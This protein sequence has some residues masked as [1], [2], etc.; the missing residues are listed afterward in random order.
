MCHVADARRVLGT[1]DLAGHGS[2]ALV[3][4]AALIFGNT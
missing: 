1:L 4:I 2:G 3:F